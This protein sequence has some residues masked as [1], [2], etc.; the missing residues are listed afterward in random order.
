MSDRRGKHG[1]RAAKEE[2]KSTET[3]KPEEVKE[4]TSKGKGSK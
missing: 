2:V 4:K 3:P 1:G